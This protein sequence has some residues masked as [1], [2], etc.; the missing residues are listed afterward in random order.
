MIETEERNAP[1]KG[2]RY[3]FGI[4]ARSLTVPLILA[5]GVSAFWL[6]RNLYASSLVAGENLGE[7]FAFFTLFGAISFFAKLGLS[8]LNKHLVAMLG[9]LRDYFKSIFSRDS[10]KFREA[11]RAL[12]RRSIPVILLTV[13]AG[14]LSGYIRPPGAQPDMPPAESDMPP[15]IE[16]HSGDSDVTVSFRGAN[17]QD[18]STNIVGL[19]GVIAGIVT[20]ALGNR[21]GPPDPNGVTER[22]DANRSMRGNYVASFPIL[23]ERAGLDSAARASATDGAAGADPE[24][25]DGAA[26]DAGLNRDLVR[27]LVEALAPCGEEDGTRPVWLSVRGYASSAPFRDGGGEVLAQSGELNVRLANMRRRSVESALRAE[28]RRADAESR[29]RLTPEIDYTLPSQL[30][31]DRKFNDRPG[32]YPAEAGS[33]PQDLLTRVAYVNVLS[34]AGCAPD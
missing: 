26:Y 22:P 34:A 11:V 6:A 15:A 12:A 29:I 18:V 16:V 32:A 7:V 13:G 21:S 9:D 31:R 1:G 10:A 30:E 28:I 17:G 8:Q 2:W 23:F 33:L 14:L 3:A 27:L 19:R 4:L 25:A 5:I 24:F 20:Q